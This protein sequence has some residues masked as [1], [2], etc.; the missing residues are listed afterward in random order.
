MKLANMKMKPREQKEMATES[1]AIDAP[2]YPWGLQVRL[3]EESLDKLDM[4]TLPKVGG[5]LMLTAKVRVVG[6]SSN[7]HV[8]EKGGKHQHKSV[9]LQITDMALG[10]VPA[11]KDAADELYSKK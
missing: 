1:P 9:E 6:V 8:S 5:E 3:D 2:V 7:E 4:D 10:D 11:D